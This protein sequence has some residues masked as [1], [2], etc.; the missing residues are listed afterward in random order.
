MD[1]PALR[2]AAV[3]RT[4]MVA[5]RRGLLFGLAIA[6]ASAASAQ[7]TGVITNNG[8]TVK[9]QPSA[10]S[11]ATQTFT[12]DGSHVEG[13]RG[14]NM[15]GSGASFASAALIDSDG[16]DFQNGNASG[17][18]YAF[19]ASHTGIDIKYTNDDATAVTPSLH[20]AILPAG[21]GLFIDNP[22]LDDLLGCGPGHKLLSVKDFKQFAPDTMPGPANDIAGA[23][24]DFRVMSGSTVLYSLSGSVILAY[25]PTSH[26][27]V[28]ITDFGA[29]E[30]ALKGFRLT[31][32]P[33]DTNQFGV[34]WDATNIE[35]SDDIV[36][37]P[38]DSASFTYE[39]TVE[40]FSRT[41]C[42]A[43]NLPACVIAYSSFG[44]P[45]GRGGG[46][47]PVLGTIGQASS[48]AAPASDGLTFA[49]FGFKHPV[50]ADGV[51]SFDMDLPP[52]PEPATWTMLVLGFG[53]AGLA[54][55]R[56]PLRDGCAA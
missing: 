43:G 40:S 22:C 56:R 51:V 39:S 53:V 6:G 18:R 9:M 41:P 54:L 27:N 24:F 16:V 26:G 8:V 21:F 36:L 1:I 20:S 42:Y 5:G 48:D 15:L 2:E 13:S 55:R 38:G 11:T 10:K 44:D 33:G 47:I 19:T 29:A 37:Q 30:A 50:Y 52:A 46:I 35:V 23:S 3:R 32:L 49:T 4:A 14:G 7:V 17:G 25:D 31:A 12:Y 34:M 45:I 28:L